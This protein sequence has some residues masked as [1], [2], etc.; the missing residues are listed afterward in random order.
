MLSPLCHCAGLGAQHVSPNRGSSIT[1]QGRGYPKHAPRAL[2]AVSS[3]P[4]TTGTK[5]PGLC[6]SR[7]VLGPRRIQAAE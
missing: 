4:C 6:S 1:L 2:D 5:S 7:P 3:P